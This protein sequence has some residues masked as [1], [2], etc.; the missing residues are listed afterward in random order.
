MLEK[1]TIEKTLNQ[2]AG[3]LNVDIDGNDEV[4]L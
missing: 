4:A 3:V 2:N 1:T